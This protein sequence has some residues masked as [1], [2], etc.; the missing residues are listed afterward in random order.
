M[1]AS[2]DKSTPDSEWKK[3]LT[4]EEVRFRI[5]SHEQ[6]RASLSAVHERCWLCL[7]GHDRHHVDMFSR[8]DMYVLVCVSAQCVSAPL[9]ARL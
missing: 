9:G 3:L 8:P 1:S 2:L 6:D 5:T 4:A 7:E